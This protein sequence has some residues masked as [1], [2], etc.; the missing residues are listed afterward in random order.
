MKQWMLMI[1]AMTMAA[2]AVADSKDTPEALADRFIAAVNA[3]SQ[4]QQKAAIHPLCFAGHSPVEK[5]YLEETVAR[6]FRKT[7]SEKRTVKITQLDGGVLPLGNMVVWP[8]KPTHQLEI[9]YSAG[10]NADTTI[11]RFI[12]QEKD[13]WF[14]VVPMLSAENLKKYEEKKAAQSPPAK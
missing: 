1:V 14:I 2:A 3:K 5:A 8:V 6:D 4:E 13:R 7:I 11:I 10:E 9:E 12:A